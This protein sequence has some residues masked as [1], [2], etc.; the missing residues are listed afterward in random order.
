[1]TLFDS[2]VDT[3]LDNQSGLTQLRPVVEK[4]ILHHDII[5]IMR[6]IG[7]LDRLTFI[8]GTCL[9]A[10]YGSSRLSEDLDFTGGKGFDAGTLDHLAGALVENIE[11]K[12]GLQAEVS[13]PVRQS[14]N[15]TGG[16]VDTWKLT[17][18][19]RP[20]SRHLPAQRIHIDICAIPS[21]DRRQSVLQ[22]RYGIDLG[23]AGLV[24]AAESQIEI[25][26]D[27]ILALALRPN[28]IKNRDLWDIAW[29]HQNGIAIS[30]ELVRLKLSDRDVDPAIFLD[31]L[32]SRSSSLV[33]DGTARAS[34]E[35][36]MTRF[37]P[38]DMV[39]RTVRD[40]RFW[41][42]VCTLAE[43][44]GNTLAKDLTSSSPRFEM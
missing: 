21:H 4:E 30:P 25:F 15:D 11:E 18:Q 19:T 35:K 36:E 7:A 3:A 8:G 2:L 39:T 43:D 44:I 31:R 27:K 13:E 23:T 20:E 9:R 6:D 33:E 22:N 40:D 14:E 24:L 17:L 5:R 42:F 1:M 34:F 38:A 29:L 32:R 41:S 28:R 16:H 10:C 37:L 26:S 12:Y